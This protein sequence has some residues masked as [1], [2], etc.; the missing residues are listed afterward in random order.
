MLISGQIWGL[1]SVFNS[2]DFWQLWQF[3][4]SLCGPL[5]AT[6]SQTPTPHMRF[7]ENKRQSAIRPS[8]DRAVEALFPSFL[9]VESVS[10]CWSFCP[11]N[12]L[13][14]VR[15]AVGRNAFTKYQVPKPSTSLPANC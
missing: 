6:L 15:S 7:V 5:P 4:Q 2:G 9:P 3:W 11:C 14:A 12:P 1:P 10:F 8:G 13:P